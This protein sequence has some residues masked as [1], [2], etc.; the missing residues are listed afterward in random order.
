MVPLFGEQPEATGIEVDL[1]GR[2]VDRY[3]SYLAFPA[4]C[5]A[6]GRSLWSKVETG[7][8]SFFSAGNVPTQTMELEF[9]KGQKKEQ[10]Y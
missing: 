4:D 6:S 9:S 8:T 5:L 10:V 3:A 2:L 7:E 1:H